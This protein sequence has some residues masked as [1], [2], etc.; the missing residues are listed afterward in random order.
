MPALN[1]LASKSVGAGEQ[2]GVLGVV[3]SVASL[4]RA[5]GPVIGALLIESA[6]APGRMDDHSLRVTF[7]TSAAI[8]L[9]A[10]ALTI[11]FAR[12]QASDPPGEVLDAG[13]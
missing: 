7:W 5:V 13:Y 3:N 6:T 10:L 1:S 4:A 8:M 12:V 11:R 2:G 9:A